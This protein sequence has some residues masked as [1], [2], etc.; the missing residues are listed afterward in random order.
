MQANKKEREKAKRD[1]KEARKLAAQPLPVLTE[2]VQPR[3]CRN[4][5]EQSEVA[6]WIAARKA[7][8]P[9]AA[10]MAK[11]RAAAAATAATGA[12]LWSACFVHPAAACLARN[13]L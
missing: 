8:F 12:L 5:T 11:K 3:P 13:V 9:T 4:A 6:E 10:N 1:R 7:R 2:D